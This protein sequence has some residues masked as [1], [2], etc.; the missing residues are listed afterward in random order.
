MMTHTQ[1]RELAGSGAVSVFPAD[2][3]SAPPRAQ[4]CR[5]AVTQALPVPGAERRR[6]PFSP[7]PPQAGAVDSFSRYAVTARRLIATPRLADMPFRRDGS[8][9]RGCHLY[10]ARRVTFLTCADPVVPHNEAY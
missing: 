2:K 4:C 10:F 1:W 8:A 6:D 9:A 3:I 7:A 5:Y